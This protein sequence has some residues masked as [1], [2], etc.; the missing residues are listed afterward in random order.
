MQ[1]TVTVMDQMTPIDTV[2][3]LI[4]RNLRRIR[5][6]RRLPQSEI[7]GRMAARGWNWT[8]AKISLIEGGKR[9]L[10]LDE[11]A[12]L[13]A[14]LE[15]PLA[16]LLSVG[17]L[18]V[19]D[20]IAYRARV[21]TGTNDLSGFTAA[22]GLREATEAAKRAEALRRIEG[23]IARA[24]FDADTATNRERV[25]DIA[26]GLFDH[27]VLTERDARVDLWVTVDQGGVGAAL[28][29][30]H[31]LRREAT[32]EIMHEMRAT[33]PGRLMSSREAFG[34]L[35]S[36]V[37]R[38]LKRR[39]P[40]NPAVT[41]TAGQYLF[42][43]SLLDEARARCAGREDPTDDARRAVVFEAVAYLEGHIPGPDGEL[44]DAETARRIAQD[45]A[46][47]QARQ[48]GDN[49]SDNAGVQPS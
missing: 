39:L 41:A 21:L 35:S 47:M 22:A 18:A 40:D 3:D 38:Q 44:L 25:A 15:V 46:L 33:V 17:D 20:E 26:S 48:S 14:A 7:A 49:Y 12:D 1:G 24:L 5:S 16:D 9:G 6:I 11:V 28:S 36:R 34:A 37:K 30:R 19:T 31:V 32:L 4:A 45:A 42:G 27:D 13:C 10:S 29:E 8:A 23:R 43:R 2:G